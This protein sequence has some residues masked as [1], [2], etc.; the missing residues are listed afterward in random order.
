MRALHVQ[1]AASPYLGLHSSV[2]EMMDPWL[3]T[4]ALATYPPNVAL[5]NA[6]AAV[7]AGQWPSGSTIQPP[8][9]WDPQFL[10]RQ[11]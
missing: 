5:D 7:A 4:H 11:Q 2:Q 8:P 9:Q 1:V 10:G 3:N 6:A